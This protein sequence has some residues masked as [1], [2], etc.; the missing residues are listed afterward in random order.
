[1][2][3]A[4]VATEKQGLKVRSGKFAGPSSKSPGMAHPPAPTTF[5]H[6][7]RWTLLLALL[8][9][10][11]CRPDNTVAPEEPVAA[12]RGLAT[13]LR[14]NDLERYARLSL[15]PRLYA[16]LS[17]HEAAHPVALAPVE[18]DKYEAWL[19]RLRAADAE[20]E[21]LAAYERR[22][23]QV[24]PELQ[25]QWP[26]MQTTLGIFLKTVIEA[27]DALTPAEK[28]HAQQLL[29][30]LLAHAQP[31]LLVDRQRAGASIRELVATAR[32]LPADSVAALQALPPAEGRR[33][34]GQL[35][36]SGKRLAAIYGI[37]LDAALAAVRVSLTSS[38]G[39]EAI[40]RVEYP[41]AGR[42]IAFDFPLRRIDGR[43]Y[44]ADAVREAE[45]RLQ[46]A[47]PAG[48]AIT[49]AR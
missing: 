4:L 33:Q 10:A 40:A 2:G 48:A 34:A 25:A 6:L 31:E 21:L 41:L 15:P 5:W 23:R 7:L 9:L 46:V 12:V 44:P 42:K 11:A 29:D 43:W 47:A 49:G 37:D 8:G 19:V 17:A 26:M 39:D 13:A 36:A 30:A 32:A 35:L 18:R 16:E 20:T 1:M 27:N 22:L 24:E 45:Q 28:D 14:E 38:S 3:G